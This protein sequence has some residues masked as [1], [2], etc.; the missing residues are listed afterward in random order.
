MQSNE[1]L[2]YRCEVNV[3]SLPCRQLS[4]RVH[5]TSV[6]QLQRSHLAQFGARF[7]QAS[8]ERYAAP[9]APGSCMETT[10]C[11]CTQGPTL[12]DH[13]F[14][15]CTNLY[16]SFPPIRLIPQA[17]VLTILLLLW[18]SNVATLTE[19]GLGS[20]SDLCI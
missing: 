10:L 9:N 15:E 18:S 19:V 1:N 14:H 4:L 2:I 8:F 20:Q 16:R 11:E 7:Y 17:L 6:E 3:E 5:S 13:I 12:I